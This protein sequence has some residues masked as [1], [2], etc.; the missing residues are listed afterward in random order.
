MWYES[1]MDLFRIDRSMLAGSRRKFICKKCENKF[2]IRDYHTVSFTFPNN[3]I[4]NSHIN[5]L[6]KEVSIM[7]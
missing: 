2:N 4:I 6:L 3:S 1:R 7:R 5:C